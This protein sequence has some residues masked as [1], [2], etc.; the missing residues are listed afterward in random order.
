MMSTSK[1]Q[2]VGKT[3]WVFFKGTTANDVVFQQ[4]DVIYKYLFILPGIKDRFKM[5]AKN[6][7]KGKQNYWN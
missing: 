1:I 2:E 3:I 5:L 7:S 4:L 6:N